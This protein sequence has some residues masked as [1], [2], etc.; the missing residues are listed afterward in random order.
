MARSESG[1]FAGDA[2]G[3]GVRTWLD[4][5]LARRQP[6]T[7][8]RPGPGG[9][10]AFAAVVLVVASFRVAVLAG[11]W[12]CLGSLLALG[13][14]L[15]APLWSFCGFVI[16]LV[17]LDGNAADFSERVRPTL[18]LV[19]TSGLPF[20]ALVVAQI[21]HLADRSYFARHRAELEAIVRDA[22]GNES[23]VDGDAVLI[24][25]C[26]AF[27]DTYQLVHDPCGRLGSAHPSIRHAEALEHV[28]GA[29]Y[30]GEH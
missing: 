1:S 16:A 9:S 29:W 22:P 8:W 11:D 10:L 17:P 24:D 12:G 18:R 13:V 2:D 25:V 19:A 28:V 14:L 20:A 21:T 27:D 6:G 4:G 15:A 30:A 7:G 5:S 23:E 3:G 26:G